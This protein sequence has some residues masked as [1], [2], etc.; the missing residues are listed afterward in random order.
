MN[1]RCLACYEKLEV[2][3]YHPSCVKQVFGVSWI[4]TFDFAQKDFGL[5]AQKMAG[6][7][8]ISGVQPKITVELNKKN[9]NFVAQIK[10]TDKLLIIF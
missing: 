3:F 1:P 4:P 7:M 2:S 10:Y 9:K 6:Q 5:L 8:S